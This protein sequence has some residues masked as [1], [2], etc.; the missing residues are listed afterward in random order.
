MVYLIQGFNG[1]AS[2]LHHFQ[3]VNWLLE[4]SQAPGSWWMDDIKY[5][6]YAAISLFL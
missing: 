5:S 1:L 6:W 3:E 4:K 2:I